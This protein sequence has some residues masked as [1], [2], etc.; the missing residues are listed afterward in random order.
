MLAGRLDGYNIL[1]TKKDSKSPK[2]LYG[3][4]REDRLYG[5]SVIV[6]N[7]QVMVAQ[8]NNSELKEMISKSSIRDREVYN[9]L[10][11]HFPKNMYALE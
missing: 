3:M 1:W 5:K 9:A 6:E 11:Q 7:A 4:F 2:T 8:F 10:T